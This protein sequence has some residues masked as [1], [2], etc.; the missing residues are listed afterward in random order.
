[1]RWPGSAVHWRREG[2][3]MG[4]EQVFLGGHSGDH[5]ELSTQSPVLG[6]R[7]VCV[8]ERR[9]WARRG[10]DGQLSGWQ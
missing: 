5:N 4:M 8:T 1:M 2:T 6:A 7:G 10:S 3:R 9:R